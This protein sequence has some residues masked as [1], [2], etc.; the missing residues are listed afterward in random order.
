MTT[1]TPTTPSIRELLDRLAAHPMRV[2][3]IVEFPTA[4]HVRELHAIATGLAAWAR[5]AWAGPPAP[6]PPP[7]QPAPSLQRAALPAHV[8][9]PLSRNGGPQMMPSPARVQRAP[10]ST[11]QP[12][13]VGAD[14][15]PPPPPAPAAPQ[16][17]RG[18]SEQPRHFAPITRT[19]PAAADYACSDE[20][21]RMLGG[22]SYDRLHQLMHAGRWPR[23]ELRYMTPGVAGGARN[24]WLRSACTAALAARTDVRS[25]VVRRA[26]EAA[27]TPATEPPQ[28][29]LATATTAAAGRTRARASGA[30]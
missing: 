3:Y 26:A 21:V 23:P 9:R 29:G 12:A 17:T 27:R 1:L 10:T 7:K 11:P 30:A 6:P 2:D 4:E 8:S 14:P 5:N 25:A 24:F 20:V 18:A 16:R 28:A 19:E 22:I 15:A 13:D